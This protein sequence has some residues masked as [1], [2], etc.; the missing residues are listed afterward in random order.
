MTIGPV[1]RRS[2]AAAQWAM[3]VSVDEVP[4]YADADVQV[5][6]GRIVVGEQ[7][8][9]A[10]HVAAVHV[11]QGGRP[12]LGGVL[13]IVGAA[14]AAGGAAWAWVA[15]AAGA[16]LAWSKMTERR[17]VLMTGAGAQL[18]IVV[19]SAARAESIRAAVAQAMAHG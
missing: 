11:E 19:H 3:V 5:S 6:K 1:A 10:R 14:G 8:V 2:I 9:A 12:V 15:L 7:T 18:S 4:I 16:W 13:L 17:V